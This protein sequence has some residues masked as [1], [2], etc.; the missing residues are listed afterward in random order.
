M[1]DVPPRHEFRDMN[2]RFPIVLGKWLAGVVAYIALSAVVS[3]LFVHG[4]QAWANEHGDSV[5][6]IIE[7]RHLGAPVFAL[8]LICGALYASALAK[9]A[10]F[11]HTARI[12]RHLGSTY[13]FSL[14]GCVLLVR[15]QFL[16]LPDF[17]SEFMLRAYLFAAFS[18]AVGCFV[19]GLAAWVRLAFGV[20]RTCTKENS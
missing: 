7:L 12:W 14:L 10:S 3:R 5:G 19:L 4:M 6:F 8:C 1:L 13:L 20:S 9:P 2:Y 17:Q 11:G 18:L 16:P 15:T